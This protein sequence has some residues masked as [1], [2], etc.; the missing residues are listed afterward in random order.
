MKTS[1]FWVCAVLALSAC[2]SDAS[3]EADTSMA[4][5]VAASTSSAEAIASPADTVETSAPSPHAH[6]D[7]VGLWVGQEGL[8]VEV[9]LAKP[10]QYSL[11][12]MGDPDQPD[13]TVI[14]AGSDAPGGIRFER[15]GQ[16]HLLRWVLG[17]EIGLKYLD[18][19]TNCLMVQ[20]GEGFCR[21]K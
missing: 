9:S 10:G 4:Q 7:W 13:S 2:G 12:M 1:G 19:E 21:K 3:V 6:A 5:A 15:D 14:L 20:E 18:G 11:K 17:D 16:Q 8:F